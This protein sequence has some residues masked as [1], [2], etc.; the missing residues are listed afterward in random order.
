MEK[1]L[2]MI[3]LTRFVTH[4]L[5]NGP[6]KNPSVIA[7]KRFLENLEN[8]YYLSGLP[9]KMEDKQ[10][11]IHE[12][13]QF[14]NKLNEIITDKA[15]MLIEQG[16]NQEDRKFMDRLL[17]EVNKAIEEGFKDDVFLQGLH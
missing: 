14:M 13:S 9:G 3:R 15:K 10:K 16:M 7:R 12:A 4:Q 17:A 1:N 8:P 11:Q 6:E 2:D 5:I